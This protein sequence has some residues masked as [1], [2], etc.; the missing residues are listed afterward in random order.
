MAAQLELQRRIGM[1]LARVADRLLSSH[2]AS[3]DVDDGLVA[4][5]AHG[6]L[7]R[8]SGARSIDAFLNQQ[9]LPSLSDEL[10]TRLVSGEVTK[11]V[12]LSLSSD[13]QLNIDFTR[14]EQDGLHPMSSP[15]SRAEANS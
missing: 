8:E 15:A 2:G 6:C 14:K 9:I 11:D 12:A 4:T 3:L 13:G 7:N 1:K 5:L 10:L